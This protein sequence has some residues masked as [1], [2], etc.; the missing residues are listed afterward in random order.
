MNLD[1]EWDKFKGGPTVAL[2]NR[3]HVTLN[4]KGEFYLNQ[5]AYRML[6]K[7]IA[8]RLY[9]N[10][11]RDMIALE[12]SHPHLPEAFPVKE[13][14]PGVGAWTIHAAPFCKHYGIRMTTTESF[15]RPDIDNNGILILELANTV[16]VSGY[17]SKRRQNREI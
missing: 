17:R 8:V 15:V 11:H 13:K 7:P 4:N 12:P 16:T 3:V 5:N 1:K 6:G 10:R 2:K 14:K 9:F